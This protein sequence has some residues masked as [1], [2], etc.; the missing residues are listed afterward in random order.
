MACKRPYDDELMFHEGRERERERFLYGPPQ[1]PSLKLLLLRTT[2][3]YFPSHERTSH[4]EWS[5]VGKKW[6]IARYPDTICQC[7]T[8]PINGSIHFSR[9]VKKPPTQA[10]ERKS[11]NDYWRVCVF[12]PLPQ[13]HPSLTLSHSNRLI[14]VR[15]TYVYI[16]R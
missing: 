3:P 4:P 8:L 13:V 5:T 15:S 6:H 1:S 11:N 9:T 12:P 7:P 14:A 16:C 2:R 10:R